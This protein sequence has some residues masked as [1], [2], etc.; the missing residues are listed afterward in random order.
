M[1]AK[2]SGLLD[3]KVTDTNGDYKPLLEEL[4]LLDLKTGDYKELVLEN[5]NFVIIT[6]DSGLY[7]KMGV[8]PHLYH[9]PKTTKNQEKRDELNGEV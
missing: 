9:T 6:K 7:G 1:V 4:G 5:G 8:F 3:L 2:N